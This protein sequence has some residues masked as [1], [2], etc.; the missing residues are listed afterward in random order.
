[1][2][3][4]KKVLADYYASEVQK[5]ADRLWEE[6]ALN[7]EAIERILDEHWTVPDKN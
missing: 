2:L 1:M 7:A 5:E 6:G 4:L 3:E